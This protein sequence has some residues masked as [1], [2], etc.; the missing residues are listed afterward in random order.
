MKTSRIQR[1]RQVG[2][3]TA[4]ASAVLML[5]ATGSAWAQDAQTITVTGIRAAIESAISVKK[6]AGNIVESLNAEDIGKMPDA[7][8]AES[9]SR[10]PGVTAQRDPAT[11][12]SKNI[13]VRG[14][15]P[16]FNGTTL[17]GREMASTGDSRAVELDQFPAELVSQV[18]IHKTSNA[19]L[20]AQ[21]IAST[22]D[23]RTIRPLDR[24]ERVISA[25]LRKYRTGVGTGSPEGDGDRQSFSY[26]DQFA[27][28]TIGVAF[29]YAK[30]N[31]TGA[32]GSN[33]G[34]NAWGRWE[35]SLAYPGQ[36]AGV[37]APAGY[38]EDVLQNTNKREGLMAVLQYKPNK[39]FE[40]S[41]DIFKSKGSFGTKKTGIEG[42]I[43]CQPPSK[44]GFNHP[45]WSCANHPYQPVVALKPGAPSS[46]V[47]A[48]GKTYLDSGT[49]E[50]IK[51]VIRNHLEAGADS[52][53]AFGW[54][55]KFKAMGWELGTDLAR[56]KVKR[57]SDRFETTAGVP[58]KI[59][60]SS[61][62][63]TAS[64]TGFAPGGPVFESTLKF[65]GVD[66]A[67]RN[68]VKLT[69][70]LGWSGGETFPQA[71]YNAN[72]NVTDTLNSARVTARK[73]M[74]WGWITSAEFGL[75]LVD[76]DKV[77]K[78]PE[79]VLRILPG[80]DP[81]GAAT[82]PGSG[83]TYL[84]T[85]GINVVS[86][87]P[88]GSVGTI[89]QRVDKIDKDILAKDWAV[90]EK[91]A[92]GYFMGDL[93]G[94]LF[95]MP[96]TGNVGLQVVSAKQSSTGFN[97]DSSTC[98]SA[99]TCAGNSAVTIRADHSYTDVNPSLNLNM[100]LGGD[101]YVRLG[102]AQSV[103]RPNM[104][105]LRASMSYDANAS[106]PTGD[107][108]NPKLEPFRAQTLDLSFEKYF[109]NKGYVSAAAF[110]KKLDSYIV[111]RSDAFDYS[112]LK[113][114]P[115]GT[116]VG[117]LTRPV[118]AKGGNISGIELS[119]NVP[120]NM[121]TPVLDGFGVFAGMSATESGIRLPKDGLKTQDLDTTNV[122]LP[123]LSKSVTNVRVYYE[124][125]GFRVS[126]GA[127]NRSDFLGEIS[128]FQDE[129][130]LTYIKGDTT[131]DMQL[132]YEFQAG[133]FKGVS[134]FLEGYNL[135]NET[136]QRY[137]DKPSNALAPIKYGKT[138]MAG[139]S[140]KF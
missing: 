49:V 109:G 50:G 84:P 120:L 94:K 30:V 53:D 8:I 74:S 80:T 102:L 110:Y 103:T 7:T 18:A 48:D 140:Y 85:L 115:A 82:V 98:S 24:R 129:R 58:G 5:G 68:V 4:V 63:G 64:W 66:Y 55:T 75:N 136:F 131:V 77:R 134:L 46:L 34:S 11:G 116:N 113:G 1:A 3:R 91:V 17:N 100:E 96:V 83:L 22:I 57:E 95:G 133:L 69:D 62:G 118:N 86:F 19:S 107:A 23:L 72:P 27:N 44:G 56:S 101:K 78:A 135:T 119:V 139:L 14:M 104:N 137:R 6:N 59:T 12:R 81:F 39:D 33:G 65:G 16:D 112:A 138:Y 10:L 25:S 79:G 121:L 15:S 89:Y 51:A 60:T 2:S 61:A 76:R 123:G 99:A 28:R 125:A 90:N 111:R 73:D 127:R 71:G 106:A 40:T 35:Q 88:R 124:K 29:G 122:P 130:S 20:T 38:G 43:S 128:N 52:L 47:T 87:D 21:G 31:D 37:L 36:P 126:L 13:S 70:V 45:D 67:D 97:V 41:L 132:G 117:L 108:G 54:N 92:T 93:E 42:S 26:V 32:S 114:N 105:D 9:I